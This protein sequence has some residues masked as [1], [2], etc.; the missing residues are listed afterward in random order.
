MKFHISS[1]ALI[2]IDFYSSI[3]IDNKVPRILSF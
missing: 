1:T 2:I 3:T